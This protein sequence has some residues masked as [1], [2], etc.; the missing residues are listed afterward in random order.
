M[1]TSALSHVG[2]VG[3]RASIH[4]RTPFPLPVPR[5]LN[6]ATDIVLLKR[7]TFYKRG[8][9]GCEKKKPKGI[10]SATKIR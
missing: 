10:K 6:H 4:G 2:E 7:A 9:F 5:T 3:L 1:L 8:G